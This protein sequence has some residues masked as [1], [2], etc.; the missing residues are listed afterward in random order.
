MKTVKILSF[1]V[2]TLLAGAVLVLAQEK[3]TPPAAPAP[4]VQPPAAP[5]APA[6]AAKP[7]EPP[8]APA[9]AAAPEPEG[10]IVIDYSDADLSSVLRTLAA[11]AGV[12]LMLGE[13]VTGKVTLHLEGIDY[14]K[15]M[16]IIVEN[17]GYAYIKDDKIVRVRSRDALDTAPVEVKVVTLNYSKADDVKKT[18]EPTLSKQGKI[19]I[20]ARSNML[21][22][23]DTPTNLA[24]LEKL[25]SEIDAQT[26]QV[27][28]EARFVETT[29]NPKKDLG[30]NWNGAINNHQVS[31]RRPDP[32]KD[33][34]SDKNPSPL[35]FAKK[36]GPGGGW[37]YP[38]AIIDAGEFN[39]VISYFASDTDT[40]LLANP[41]VVTT[42]NGKAKLAIAQQY[43]IPNFSY[44]EQQGAFIISGFEYKDIGIVLNVTP[45]INKNSF[46]TLDVAPEVSSSAENAKLIGGGTAVEIPIINTR[47]ATTTVLIKSGN[48]LA[49]GGLM[50][51]DNKNGFTK[52]PVMGDIPGIGAL[53][54]SKSLDK[55]KRELLIFVTPTILNANVN[56]DFKSETKRVLEGKT[57]ADDEWMPED[58]AKPN[59]DNLKPWKKKPAASAN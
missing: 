39:W 21:V 38:T 48:T 57:Y 13:E 3:V 12:N 32:K 18:I 2:G 58:N 28:I 11:R 5:P 52:V 25:I 17:K 34:S 6:D 53:F 51:Q 31:I 29:K 24:K 45:R 1:A 7:A 37:S 42:D 14:E 43:P 22:L 8:A 35:E 33:L 56:D 47:T 59:P 55:K 26:P 19:Q 9:P 49:I 30:I 4:E 16:K 10:P 20:D 41:R 46:V 23:S 36:L 44:S 40:E 27:M 54:R 50:Q 15:A